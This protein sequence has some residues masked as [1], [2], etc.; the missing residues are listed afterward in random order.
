MRC[1]QILERVYFGLVGSTGTVAGACATFLYNLRMGVD[2]IRSGRRRVVMVGTSEAPIMP[3]VI[4]GY[5]AMGAL[6]TDDGLKKI[7]G[8]DVANHRRASRPFGENCGFTL[9]ESAQFIIL[10]DDALALEMGAEI[11]G[12][13]GNVFV[14]ADGHKKSISAPGAGNYITM[15]K[16]LASARALL[17]DAA[18]A[19]RSFVQAHGSSTPQNRVTESHILNEA[20]KAFGMKKWPVATMKAFLGHSI[21]SAA[22]DQITAS[23]GVWQYGLI[24]GI[25]TIDKAADDV[26]A[27]H[28]HIDKRDLDVGRENMDLAVINAKGLVATT[29][30]LRCSHRMSSKKCC[31]KNT[32][33]RL[34]PLGK[35]TTSAF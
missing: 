11:F 17:G 21:G 28:L 29:R 33:R 3:E 8:S 25:K 14:N 35:K 34:L 32:G 2:D 27:S 16:A 23:L 18:V 6:A 22:G 10:M 1:P 4:D 7:D 31:R 9:A 5:D 20:A 24:P 15:A 30:Q 19:Q 13:V 12:A 26:H